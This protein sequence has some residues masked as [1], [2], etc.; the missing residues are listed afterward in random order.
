VYKQADVNK[1]KTI[2]AILPAQTNLR[3]T[4]ILDEKDRTVRYWITAVNQTN[5]ESAARERKIT[6]SLGQTWSIQ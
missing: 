3:W 1:S 5:E 6:R 4:D 2:A